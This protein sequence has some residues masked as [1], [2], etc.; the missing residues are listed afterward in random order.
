LFCFFQ[1]HHAS[2]FAVC[3]NESNWRHSDLPVDAV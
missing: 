1:R 2:V 3:V